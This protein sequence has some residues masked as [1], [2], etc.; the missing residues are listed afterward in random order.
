MLY[1]GIHPLET[2]HLRWSDSVLTEGEIITSNRLLQGKKPPKHL[3]KIEGF[4]STLRQIVKVLG[5]SEPLLKEGLRREQKGSC[6][7]C[8][9]TDRNGETRR[10]LK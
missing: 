2:A 3:L 4:T 9:E 8:G 6:V 5:K 1:A 7:L 10:F